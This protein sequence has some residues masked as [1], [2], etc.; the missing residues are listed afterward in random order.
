M[1]DPGEII[2]FQTEDGQT[3]IDVRLAHAGFVDV[4]RREFNPAMD[5]ED[6]RIGTLYMEAKRP[7]NS[8][9]G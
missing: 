7:G 2:L 6:R 5:N 3:R 9:N 8:A 1:N 4:R